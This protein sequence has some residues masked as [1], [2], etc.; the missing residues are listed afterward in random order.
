MK[1]RTWLPLPVESHSMQHA[2]IYNIEEKPHALRNL[3]HGLNSM[4][5]IERKI[6]SSQRT[7]MVLTHQERSESSEAMLNVPC[8]SY[9]DSL[10]LSHRKRIEVSETNRSLNRILF[11]IAGDNPNWYSYPLIFLLKLILKMIIVL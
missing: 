9:A 3:T 6:V 11:I 1:N 7:F 10:C 2:L 5:L 4:R 8:C